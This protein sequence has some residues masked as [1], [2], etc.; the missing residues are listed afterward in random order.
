MQGVRTSRLRH[1]IEADQLDLWNVVVVPTQ[2]LRR[3]FQAHFS[4]TNNRVLAV[5]TIV[6]FDQSGAI[7]KE[8]VQGSSYA[9][10][11][12]RVVNAQV[13]ACYANTPV[14]HVGR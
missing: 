10:T 12:K 11:Q 1:A 2:T 9:C 5:N 13:E 7:W 3:T 8:P 4:A 14:L 6:G